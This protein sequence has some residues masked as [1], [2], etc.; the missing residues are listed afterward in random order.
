MLDKSALCQQA[1]GQQAKCRPASGE[2][3]RRLPW[4]FVSTAMM[5]LAIA[6]ACGET[7]DDGSDAGS[8]GMSG[9]ATSGGESAGGSSSAGESSAGESTAGESTAGES[10]NGGSTS[11]GSTSG[12]STSG[13]TS[14]GGEPPAAGGESATGGAAGAAGAGGSDTA[15]SSADECGWGEIDHEILDE[16]DCPCLYGCPYLPLR[17]ETV[18]RRIDQ[19]EELCTPG[20]DGGGRP[21]G[22]DDCALPPEP[23]CVDNTCG[24][25]DPF[26]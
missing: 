5:S 24:P 13:G 25:E 18:D 8:A 1:S 4:L 22:I 11:G 7:S 6:G 9:N 19:Y 21:C 17:Q 15:C 12:G 20:V 2:R 10:A 23:T 16:A 26:G 14:S 3:K